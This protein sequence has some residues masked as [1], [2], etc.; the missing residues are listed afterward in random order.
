MPLSEIY[1]I[2]SEHNLTKEYVGHLLKKGN[3]SLFEG[4]LFLKDKFYCTFV[5]KETTQVFGLLF[6][7]V[8]RVF[9]E[10]IF[11]KYSTQKIYYLEKLVEFFMQENF[12]ERLLKFDFE[13][14]LRIVK[15]FFDDRVYDKLLN[16]SECQK[17]SQLVYGKNFHEVILDQ[18][19]NTGT[20]DNLDY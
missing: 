19:Q 12:L 5:F 1:V 15:W 10:F 8:Q 11:N 17:T 20:I 16:S 7:L 6:N 13:S 9:E 2:S 3:K 14:T 18:V 4:L